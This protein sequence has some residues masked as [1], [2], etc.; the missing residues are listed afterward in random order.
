MFLS[1]MIGLIRLIKAE[2][3]L[4]LSL[5]LSLSLRACVYEY[6]VL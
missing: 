6:L 5:S 3:L 1:K 2:V 4:P